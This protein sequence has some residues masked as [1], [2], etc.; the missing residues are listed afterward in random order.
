[1][2]RERSVVPGLLTQGN[3]AKLYCLERIDELAL[4]RGGRLRI[5]DLGC[6]RA[7]NFV[8][9]LSRHPDVSYVGVEPDAT[10]CRDAERVLTGLSA[11]IVHAAAYDLALPPAD[12]VV[13]FSVLEHVYRRADYIKSLAACLAPDGVAFVN[14][15]AGHFVGTGTPS[16]RRRER[17]KS[18]VGRALARAGRE[19]LYQAFVREAD[20]RRWVADAGLAV[21]DDKVFNTDLKSVWPL[22]E[23]PARPEFMREWLALELRINDL[24]VEYH[25]GLA[26]YFRTR[27]FILRLA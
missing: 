13:S 12:V 15:D 6:G 14:Y 19:Q 10:A 24:G 5:V 26:R 9:L 16:A 1:M 3:A 7:E 22:L 11:E 4:D 20:F 27:N 25:D 21:A 8:A 23:E 17:L 2:P 18:A